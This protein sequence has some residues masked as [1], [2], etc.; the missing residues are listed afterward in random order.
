M[1]DTAPGLIDGR[2]KALAPKAPDPP[3]VALVRASVNAIATTVTRAAYS[4]EPGPPDMGPRGLSQT[5]RAV[6]QALGSV[7]SRRYECSLAL[8]VRRPMAREGT[9]PAA[10]WR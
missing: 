7:L 8:T 9:R 3:S 6:K 2:Y 4:C 5:E 1:G 10:S